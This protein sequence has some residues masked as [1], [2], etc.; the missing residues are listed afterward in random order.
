MPI[1]DYCCAAC[2]AFEQQRPMK[3]SGEPAACPACDALAPRVVAA[4]SLNLMQA[5][6]R[7]AHA[8]NE[9]SAHAPEVVT[10]AAPDAAGHRRTH[11]QHHAPAAHKPARPWMVGH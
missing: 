2:G 3:E 7:I 8:R 1:Y 6:N 5:T 4:P 9:K 10:R 11:H